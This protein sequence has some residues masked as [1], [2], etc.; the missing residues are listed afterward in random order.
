MLK[1]TFLSHRLT[2]KYPNLTKQ[3]V[4]DHFEGSLCRC[5][6]KYNEDCITVRFTKVGSDLPLP[7][8]SALM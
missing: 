7:K 5:T 1:Y 4:E 6:G 3:N 2:Q 8:T